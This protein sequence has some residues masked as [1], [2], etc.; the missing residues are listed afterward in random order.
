MDKR[1]KERMKVDIIGE[2]GY[3]QAALGFSLSYNSTLERAKQILPKYAFKNSGENKF[4]RAMIVWLDITA[5]RFWLTELDTY[6]IS[7]VRLSAST[8]HTLTKNLVTSD[9][10]EYPIENEGIEILNDAI[11]MFNAPP[12]NDEERDRKAYLP[13]IKNALPEGYLQRMVFSCSYAT[14]QNIYNQRK[15]HRLPQW[16]VFLDKVLEQVEHPEFIKGEQK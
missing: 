1:G 14:L 2:Y 12:K 13:L 3:E 7:T 15:N 10:F 16:G 5:P 8:M 9:D 6:K 4:L 11:K